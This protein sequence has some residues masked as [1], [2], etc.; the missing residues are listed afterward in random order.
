MV[1]V[2][3]EVSD[4]EEEHND[5]KQKKAEVKDDVGTAVE[6]KEV[7]EKQVD[8]EEENQKEVVEAPVQDGEPELD[9]EMV[10]VLL[11]V[12]I[13]LFFVLF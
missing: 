2:E 5:I 12:G 9:A 6:E 3:V 13:C 1:L 4:E 10:V 7:E 8:A 11:V